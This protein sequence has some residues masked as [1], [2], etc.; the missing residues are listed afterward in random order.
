[1]WYFLDYIVETINSR[2]NAAFDIT[3]IILYLYNIL[4]FYANT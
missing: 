3:T 1:M 2:E 4:P